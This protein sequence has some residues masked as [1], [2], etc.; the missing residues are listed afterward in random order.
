MAVLLKCQMIK[1]TDVIYNV[2][3]KEKTIKTNKM[4]IMEQADGAQESY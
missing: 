4:D 3:E 1:S 2:Q